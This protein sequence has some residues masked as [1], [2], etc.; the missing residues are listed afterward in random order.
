MIRFCRIL[1]VLGLSSMLTVRAADQRPNFIV[2][3]C[4][5]LGYGDLHCYGN[6]E[7]HTPNLDRF[8]QEGL[9]LTSC[10][11]SHPN[12]SPSRTGLM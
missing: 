5:D 7:L 8:A 3:L 11:S 2:V 4:D 10:Y 12:C 6:D 1:L 9:R